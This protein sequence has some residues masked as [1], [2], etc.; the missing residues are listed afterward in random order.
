MSPYDD[1]NLIIGGLYQCVDPHGIQN[2]QFQDFVLLLEWT[3]YKTG[4]T[5]LFQD[6]ILKLY[7]DVYYSEDFFTSFRFIRT[8]SI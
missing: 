6:K 8:D 5:V 4:V 7:F 1:N 2:I 3:Q